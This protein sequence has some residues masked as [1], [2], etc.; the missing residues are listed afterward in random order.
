MASP[1]CDS[2]RDASSSDL[3]ER[4]RDRN[5]RDESAASSLDWSQFI[6]AGPT[7]EVLDGEREWR[8]STFAN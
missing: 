1:G 7:N 5:A 8:D 4:A 6:E 3:A 2:S